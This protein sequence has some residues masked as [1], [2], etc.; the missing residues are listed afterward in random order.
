MSRKKALWI[1][2]WLL[3]ASVAFSA[4]EFATGV[5]LIGLLS[6]MAMGGAV[7]YYGISEGLNEAGKQIRAHLLRIK[8]D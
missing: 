3:A 1:A 2:L 6:D 8:S 5:H 7:Y 4:V